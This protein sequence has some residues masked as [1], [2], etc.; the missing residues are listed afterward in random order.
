MSTVSHTPEELQAVIEAL[1]RSHA[2][3][4]FDPEGNILEANDNFCKT[5]GYR[6][7][8]VVG[9][10]HSM[11]VDPE[12]ARS[13]EYQQFWPSLAQGQVKIGEFDRIKKGGGKI[14][15]DASYN[16]I[17]GADGKA[18]K[19]VKLAK[20]VSG[21]QSKLK[22]LLSSVAETS[23]HIAS[24]A[25]SM[26]A[27]SNELS[28]RSENQAAT[29]E[30]TSAAME[31]IASIVKSNTQEAEAATSEAMNAKSI[32]EKGGEVVEKAI[33][34]MA[35]IES[36]SKEI[37]KFIEVIDSIAFQT[38]L[39]ALNAGVEA[40]RA[41]DAGRGFA[42]V[43]SEVR[44]LAQRASGSAKDINALIDSSGREVEEGARLVNETGSVLTEI[45][46]GVVKVSDGIER[47]FSASQEQESGVIEVNKAI[48]IIDQDTQRNAQMAQQS[49]EA[50][51]NLARSSAQL[52]E[53]ANQ[54]GGRPKAP[55]AS[56]ARP[57]PARAPTPMPPRRPTPEPPARRMAVN[58]TA[59]VDHE[60][61]WTEF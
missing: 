33:A 13:P 16:V 27:T 59:S 60:E 36:G 7:D 32:A 20:D 30:E 24:E 28:K 29:V 45:M 57:M 55:K 25:E 15:L 38:N 11:F 48:S 3:I 10:H 9:R 35:K 39:L 61:D 44:A 12:Y 5:M 53:M 41:G 2:V 19:I 58:E 4:W 47:I 43:A 52:I 14:K 46:E 26:A 21:H 40:A 50:A 54:F 34:A 51:G 18:S 42:V 17:L 1:N 49:S 6:A 8:E 37:R 22:S 56:V 31:E 23:A